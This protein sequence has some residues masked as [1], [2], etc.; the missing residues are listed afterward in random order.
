VDLRNGD[1]FIVM[2]QATPQ[3][4]D[5]YRENMRD[6]IVEALGLR[7]NQVVPNLPIQRI[8]TGNSKVLIPV[9]PG[10]L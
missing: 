2:T 1:Y 7:P 8:D 3:V 4:S 10:P 9:C 5:P 6:D